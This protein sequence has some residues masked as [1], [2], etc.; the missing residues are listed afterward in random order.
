MKLELLKRTHPSFNARV[1]QLHADLFAGGAQFRSHL[2]EYLP[3]HDVE[4]GAVWERRKKLSHYINYTAPIVNLFASLV[5]SDALEIE[6]EG[7]SEWWS[8]WS[9]NV[10]GLGCELQSFAKRRLVD[11][12]VSQSSWWRVELP[13]PDTTPDSRAQ[14]EAL[15]L[16]EARLVA[17]PTTS[18]VNWCKNDDGSYRWVVEYARREELEEWIDEAPTVTETWTLWNADGSARRWQSRYRKGSQQALEAAEIEPPYNPLG[19]LPLVCLELQSELYLLNLLADAQLEVFR[20]RCALSW[21]I[22]RTCYAMAVLKTK[23]KKR[24]DVMGAGYYMQLG[25]DDV[26]EWPA[27]PSSPFDTIANYIAT[28][29]D[30]V[31]RVSQQMAAGVDNNAA[32]VGRSGESKKADAEATTTVA[33]ALAKIVVQAVQKTVALI[34]KARGEQ[35][36]KVCGMDDYDGEDVAALTDAAVNAKLLEIPSPTFR[37]VLQTRIALGSIEDADE[38]TKAQIRAEIEAANTIAPSPEDATNTDA[39]DV[40]TPDA[41]AATTAGG[42][43]DGAAKFFQ[44][45]VETGVVTREEVRRALGLSGEAPGIPEELKTPSITSQ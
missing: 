16:G 17:V 32:A 31:Y 20:K 37:K 44:W 27:P 43:V 6:D 38:E 22:D 23:S 33:R 41:P 26:L 42:G 18:I 35:A 14:F 4:P 7:T 19:T 10:D 13:Q 25:V 8:A 39:Q 11:A 40:T 36:P 2:S 28:L 9:K 30:E 24:P 29:K 12:L 45:H 5:A 21:A 1:L 15:G 3:Q 34:A